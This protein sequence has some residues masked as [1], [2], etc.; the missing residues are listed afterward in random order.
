MEKKIRAPLMPIVSYSFYRGIFGGILEESRQ[1]SSGSITISFYSKL[2][3]F[4]LKKNEIIVVQNPD[5][6]SEEFQPCTCSKGRRL[7]LPS[8][9][10]HW[11]SHLSFGIVPRSSHSPHQRTPHMEAY[12]FKEMHSEPNI[13]HKSYTNWTTFQNCTSGKQCIM[14][15]YM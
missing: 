5:N 1:S 7:P 9:R 13:T 6:C 4:L 3:G 12:I 10:T 14:K 2:G 8:P 15:T 11:E